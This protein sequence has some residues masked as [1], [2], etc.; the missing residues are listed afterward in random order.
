MK[1]QNQKEII[2]RNYEFPD[3]RG[4]KSMKIREEPTNTE[5]QIERN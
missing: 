2:E 4:E 1:T 5:K 3:T